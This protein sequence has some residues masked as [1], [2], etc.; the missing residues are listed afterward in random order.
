[1][2]WWS[3]MYLRLLMMA[4]GAQVV[5]A[6]RDQRLVLMQGDGAAARMPP[7]STPP[8]TRL[9]ACLAGGHGRGDGGSE[10]QMLGR[11]STYS[12]RSTRQGLLWVGLVSSG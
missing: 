5:A 1:M 4:G 12:G 9:S 10:P 6:G 7:K 8:G 2:S 11:P 3:I